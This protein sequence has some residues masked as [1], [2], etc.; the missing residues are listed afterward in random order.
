MEQIRQ[1][2]SAIIAGTMIGVGG[3][4]FL[5]QQ[6][7]VVGSF[8]FGIGLFTVAVLQLQLYTGKIGYLP[9]QKPSY[10]LELLITWVGNLVGTFVVGTLIRH[11]RLYEGISE[12]ANG[13][14]SLKLEDSYFSL[15]ILGIFCGILMFLA[16]DTFRRQDG[17]TTKMIALFVPVMVFILAGFEHVVANMFYFSLTNAWNAKCWMATVVVTLGNSLGGMLIPLYLKIFHVREN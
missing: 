1:F 11:T 9:F 8:L 14:V 10:L 16:I 13:I 4:V 15:F 7:P 12:R 17:S 6:N 3:T 5:V 2:F